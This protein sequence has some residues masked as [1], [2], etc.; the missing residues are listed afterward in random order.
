[1]TRA[2][3]PLERGPAPM[4]FRCSSMAMRA[5]RNCGKRANNGIT[6]TYRARVEERGRERERERETKRKREEIS[7]TDVPL[8]AILILP[9]NQRGIKE[10][11]SNRAKEHGDRQG[12]RRETRNEESDEK[13]RREEKKGTERKEKCDTLRRGRTRQ[14]YRI[15]Q[16]A[17]LHGRR[18]HF[19]REW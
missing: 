3:G 12:S 17:P 14:E 19:G 2:T 13:G 18:L 7:S 6:E 4:P 8:S 10:R 16:T 9:A 1:L 15:H 11:D 5:R